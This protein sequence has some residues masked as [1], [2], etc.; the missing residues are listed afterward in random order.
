MAKQTQKKERRKH[1]RAKRV[2]SIEHR[3]FKRKG[4]IVDGSWQFS[5][6]ENMSIAGILFLSDIPYLIGDILQIHVVM[7]GILDVF[8]GYGRV[9]R[10]EPK[11]SGRSYLIAIAF[12]DEQSKLIKSSGTSFSMRTRTKEHSGKTRRAK[13]YF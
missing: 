12:I 6:T 9:V 10:V 5:T 8:Q 3:L 13:Y 11:T 7:S 2:L 4:K 1:L